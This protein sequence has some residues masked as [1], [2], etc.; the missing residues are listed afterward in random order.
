MTTNRAIFHQGKCY[1]SLQNLYDQNKTDESPK[2][3]SFVLKFKKLNSITK[4][5][6]YDGKKLRGKLY[7]SLYFEYQNNTSVSKPLFVKRMRNGMKP[8][9][10]IMRRPDL[11]RMRINNEI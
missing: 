2:Y 6:K 5:L 3:S 11:K 9:Y 10:A 1:K 4:A 8:R 7:K